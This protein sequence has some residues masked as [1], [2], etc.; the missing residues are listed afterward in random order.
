MDLLYREA[1]AVFVKLLLTRHECGFDGVQVRF[2]CSPCEIVGN[3][4]VPTESCPNLIG[5]CGGK[6]RPAS[7]EG[8]RERF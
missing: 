3:F 8:T 2:R 4:G 5:K 7:G 6:L 1:D